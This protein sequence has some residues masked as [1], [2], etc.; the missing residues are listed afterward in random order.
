M[1]ARAYITAASH[2][3]EGQK[4]LRGLQ[5]P[6]YFLV[7]Q[8]IELSLKAVL[9]KFGDNNLRSPHIRHNTLALVER[10]KR[11]TTIDPLFTTA[12]HRLS[13]YHHQHLFR[14]GERE[15]YIVP[16]ARQLLDVVSRQIT[17]FEL[18]I[19]SGR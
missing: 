12:A 13:D 16:K 4:V 2:L 19:F 1:D 7:S 9:V 3:C 6:F 10:A 14:Y 11:H 15:L 17:T 8:S 5:K 18:L